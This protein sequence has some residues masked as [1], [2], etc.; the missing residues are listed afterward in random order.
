MRTE[1][2]KLEIAREKDQRFIQGQEKQLNE[3][4]QLKSQLEEQ[5][6]QLQQQ[7]KTEKERQQR[8]LEKIQQQVG[9]IDMDQVNKLKKRFGRCN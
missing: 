4:S 9:Q 1:V 2:T 8:K 3:L 5:V 7:L 6:S